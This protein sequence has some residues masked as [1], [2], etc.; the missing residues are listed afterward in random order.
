MTNFIKIEGVLIEIRDIFVLGYGTATSTVARTV[1]I[2]NKRSE[3]LLQKN[4]A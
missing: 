4:I 3:F 1:K 2:V